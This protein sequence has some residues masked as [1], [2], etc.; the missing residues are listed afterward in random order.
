MSSAPT[1]PPA[2]SLPER[3]FAPRAVP[4]NEGV[5]MLR[6]ALALFT[7]APLRL[8]GLYLLF[9]LPV[10]LLNGPSWL[11][12]PVRVTI[13]AII[14]AGLFAALEAVRRGRP[15]G[16]RDMFSPWLLPPGK[17]I[18][19]GLSGAA[20]LLGDWLVW[21]ADLG[22]AALQQLLIV[23]VP[24]EPGPE[25][26]AAAVQALSAANPAFAQ[27]LEA[28]LSENLLDIPLLLLAPLCV[29]HPWS[30]TRTLAANLI[31]SLRNWHWGVALFLFSTP[32]QLGFWVAAPSL[33]IKLP[34]VLV[35]C[36]LGI[37][38]AGFVLALMHRALDAV[39][40]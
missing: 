33:A 31:A 12:L 27:K 17:I 21:W 10:V 22:G 19:L 9:T 39:E 1:P 32:V 26:A 29:L 23:Y 18:L 37:I 24:P 8:L 2:V 3:G 28:S 30:A 4:W 34:L 5:P 7:A 25:G 14:D 35:N 15:P 13:A 6:E 38:T 40:H 36:V 20:L 11:A 16:L